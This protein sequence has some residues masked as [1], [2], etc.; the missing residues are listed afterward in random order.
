MNETIRTMMLRTCE[1]IDR[2]GDAYLAAHPE[3]PRYCY[4]CQRWLDNAAAAESHKG[5]SIH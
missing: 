3:T 2:V 5:H 4:T 1:A